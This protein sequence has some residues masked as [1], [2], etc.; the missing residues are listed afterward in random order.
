MTL[1]EVKQVSS[2]CMTRT[3]MYIT[4]SVSVC[5]IS[6]HACLS[7]DVYNHSA[8]HRALWQDLELIFR[9]LFQHGNR[10]ARRARIVYASL[11]LQKRYVC[12]SET[13]RSCTFPC[14]KMCEQS[15][16]DCCWHSK[17][18]MTR[19]RSPFPC[20][21]YTQNAVCTTYTYANT[22]WRIFRTR[23]R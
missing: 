15:S 21:T 23:K 3:R 20:H 11:S 10:P 7:K 1:V 9:R 6:M 12:V 13:H 22:D 16:A 5:S 8:A 4:V 2:S 14:T 18:C 19:I 17:V